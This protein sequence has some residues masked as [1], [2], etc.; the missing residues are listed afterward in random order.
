VTNISTRKPPSRAYRCARWLYQPAKL[1]RAS[2]ST[3]L[4][5]RH[6]RRAAQE[7]VRRDGFKG[8]QIGCGPHRVDGW[9][10]GDL[11]NNRK[12]DVYV[13]I[14]RPLPVP[15]QSLDAIYAGEVIEH[16]AEPAARAFAARARATTRRVARGRQRRRARR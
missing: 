11:L 13:D 1:A 7:N 9:L 12:R 8:L 16:V 2:I 15:D 14:T 3:M 6:A 4:A 10:N 5:E